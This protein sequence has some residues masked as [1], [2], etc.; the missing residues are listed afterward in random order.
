MK[1]PAGLVAPEGPEEGPA[2][3]LS[4]RLVDGPTGPL[5]GPGPTLPLLRRS[6]VIRDY[7]I[8]TCSILTYYHTLRSWKFGLQHRNVEGWGG[9][10]VQPI[11]ASSQIHSKQCSY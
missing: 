5:C 8:P 3:G 7:L 9:G 4:P 6:P 2:P 11:A 10:T 1:A